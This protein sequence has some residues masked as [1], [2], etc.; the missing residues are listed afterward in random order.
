VNESD[1]DIENIFKRTTDLG[2]GEISMDF[3]TMISYFPVADDSLVFFCK[4]QKHYI[5]NKTL[6]QSHNQLLASRK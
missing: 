1:S 5:H 2:R 6:F 4:T 3:A